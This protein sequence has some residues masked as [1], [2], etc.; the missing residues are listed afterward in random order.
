MKSL[1]DES[2]FYRPP[3]GAVERRDTVNDDCQKLVLAPARI[4]PPASRQM[5]AAT[6]S[7]LCPLRPRIPAT[8]QAERWWPKLS[9][10]RPHTHERRRNLR[11]SKTRKGCGS[12]QNERS[13][14][15]T[16]IFLELNKG[17]RSLTSKVG[18]AQPEK[19][20]LPRGAQPDGALPHQH[21]QV[22]EGERTGP[23]TSWQTTVRMK[24]RSCESNGASRTE[25][26]TVADWVVRR[27]RGPSPTVR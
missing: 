24:W 14:G 27:G 9:R 10:R 3:L 7:R 4:F 25:K 16:V 19:L 18:R 2:A 6:V 17:T 22:R 23:P 8:E 15:N 21:W 12:I 20:T 11:S 26:L 13:V 5:R 1:L